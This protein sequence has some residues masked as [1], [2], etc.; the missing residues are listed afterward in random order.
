MAYK[1]NIK[2]DVDEDDE[3]FIL[4][5]PNGYRFFD[6]VVHVRGFDSIQEIRD[7]IKNGEVIKCNCSDCK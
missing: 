1:L 6:D 5:L 7:S 2:R 3:V 4:N